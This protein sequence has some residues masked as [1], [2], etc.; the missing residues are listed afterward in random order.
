MI[1]P[2]E[3]MGHEN[4]TEFILLGLF[5]DENGELACFMLFLLTAVGTKRGQIIEPDFTE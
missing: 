4:V 2:T 1:K 5:I 3:A